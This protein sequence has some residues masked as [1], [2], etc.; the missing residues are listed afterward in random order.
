MGGARLERATSCFV[1]REHLLPP[2]AVYRPT[3]SASGISAVTAVLCCD[4]LLRKRFHVRC[5]TGD[6]RC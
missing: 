2:T 4:L 1:R 5:L 3:C 6:V